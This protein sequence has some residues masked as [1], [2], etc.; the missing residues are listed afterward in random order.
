MQEQIR[1]AVTDRLGPEHPELDRAELEE[2]VDAET[3]RLWE[4]A[5]MVLVEAHT[6][7]LTAWNT[8]HPG[9]S[10]DFQTLQG[11]YRLACQ[12]ALES[13]WTQLWEDYDDPADHH[14]R[15]SDSA[16]EAAS[17]AQQPAMMRWQT[18][19]AVQADETIAAL[20]EQVWPQQTPRF[21]VF[22]EDLLAARAFDHLPLPTGPDD[23]LVPPLTALV[24][25]AAD[26]LDA[27]MVARRR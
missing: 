20:V 14:G 22:A 23:Q 11:L 25:A 15:I 2:L 5:Q 26:Q 24:H 13:A 18:P 17:W 12:T 21:Q 1:L 3:A 6:Q 9:Q 7:A 4:S 16:I 10:A 19:H 8:R 27:A